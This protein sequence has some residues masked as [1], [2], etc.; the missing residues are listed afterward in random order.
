MTVE[1]AARERTEIS[2]QKWGKNK[3]ARVAS[4]LLR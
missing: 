4:S 1:T 2:S 3:I